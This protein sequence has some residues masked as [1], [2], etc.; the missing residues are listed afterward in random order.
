MVR[1]QAADWLEVLPAG[2]AELHEALLDQPGAHPP[3]A[4]TLGEQHIL[5]LHTP[6]IA[7]PSPELLSAPCPAAAAAPC[8]ASMP[9]DG[10]GSR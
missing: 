6:M 1:P 4:K 5:Q 10:P 9:A 3:G 7:S 2:F 8:S